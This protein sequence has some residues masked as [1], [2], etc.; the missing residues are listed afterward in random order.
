MSTVRYG[1]AARPA[2]AD[3]GQVFERFASAASEAVQWSPRVDVKEEPSRFVIL[4]DVPGVDP[5]A[6]ELQMDKNVLSIRGERAA[7]ALAENERFSR[8]ER[9]SGA[10]LR[11]FT[12]PETADADAITATGRDGVLEIVIPKRAEAAPRR[13]QV[14]RQT[15]Q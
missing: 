9:R 15:I 3:L 8:Q 4:A 6:I 2:A 13:I 11:S 10:F 1:W 12:L 5:D 7:P 14:G